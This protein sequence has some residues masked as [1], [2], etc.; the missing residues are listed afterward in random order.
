MGAAVSPPEVCCA[1]GCFSVKPGSMFV[2]KS[3]GLSAS[4]DFFTPEVSHIADSL[5]PH[6]VIYSASA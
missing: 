5:S 4:F 6:S 2:T 1:A 3:S